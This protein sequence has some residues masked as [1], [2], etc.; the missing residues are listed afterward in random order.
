MRARHW[1]LARLMMLIL[2]ASAACTPIY[3]R[4]VTLNQPLHASDIAFIT[5][6]RTTWQD[7]TAHLGIPG[8]LTPA[9]DGFVASYFY[10]DTADFN[11]DL[12][13][14]LGLIAPV[15]RLPHQMALGVTGIGTDMLQIAV[16][17]AG[18]VRFAAFA[19]GTEAAHFKVLPT[20]D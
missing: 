9:P 10:Y 7:V 14:P 15:S 5:P 17:S 19:S 13:W 16:D 4:R 3:W 20:S 11:V 1:P 2:L 12:G 18:H 8:D 6:G